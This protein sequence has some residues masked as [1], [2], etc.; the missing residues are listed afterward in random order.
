MTE[1]TLEQALLWKREKSGWCSNFDYLK[2]KSDWHAVCAGLYYYTQ[3]INKDYSFVC[4]CECH[5]EKAE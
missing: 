2:K 5:N 4:S 3:V 1:L